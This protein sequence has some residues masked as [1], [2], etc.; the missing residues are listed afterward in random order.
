MGFLESM[1]EKIAEVQK[2]HTKILL[3]IAL[4]ITIFMIFGVA[5]LQMQSDL[6]KTNPED[7]EIYKLNDRVTSK[8]GGQDTILI[9]IGVDRDSNS[10]E[11]I[12]DIRDAE[13]INYMM[14]LEGSLKQES[15]IESVSSIAG[16]YSGI[17]MTSVNDAIVRATLDQ[18][19]SLDQFFSENYEYTFMIVRSDM[20][21]G[22][23]KIVAITDL[24]QEKIDSIAKPSGIK[25]SVTG[26]PPLRVVL[27]DILKHDA[28][29]T[30]IVAFIMIFL[31]LIIMEHSLM[32][33][34]LVATPL[35]LGLIWTA[36]TLGH[37]GI[38]ISVATAGLG[39]MILGLGV[40]YGVFMLER[41][42]EE[43]SKDKDIL[44]SLK[45]SL[46]SVGTSLL[47]SGLATMI[48]FL[49]LMTSFSPM[50]QKLGFS[51]ALGIFYCLITALFIAPLIFIV[52]EDLEDKL[53][54]AIYSFIKK[55]FGRH[56]D[57]AELEKTSEKGRQK[58]SS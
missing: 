36:G 51:L 56:H 10:K 30:I 23:D 7:L 32:K 28:V 39:A 6:S 38:E 54:F 14:D 8:F 5:K 55:R 50:L 48:G 49:A 9:I 37:L 40:E 3:L 13:V 57:V 4:A 15:S 18:N 25:I 17:G 35:L 26:S 22:E 24:I 19:P 16:V 45:V 43:R 34:I 53:D 29:Y 11:A 46:P 31:L 21:G 44:S 42:D 20:G 41:Y 27:L 12:N 33:A 2:K 1:L 52:A 47:A 58:R